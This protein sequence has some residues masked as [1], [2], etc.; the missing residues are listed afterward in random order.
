MRNQRWRDEFMV[1]MGKLGLNA[2][3][4]RRLMRYAATLQRLAEAQ[5]NGDY[6]ADNGERPTKPCTNCEN[7]WAESALRKRDGV[8][9]D[10][11]TEA[12]LKDF[13]A[14]HG[15]ELEFQGDPRGC[16]VSVKRG[17]K[18]IGVPS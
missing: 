8:C 14:E 16:I 12:A 10:C 4:S 7:H 13:A 18:L 1:E 2:D 5:C 17:D 11:R 3:L 9:I 15:I 6:P